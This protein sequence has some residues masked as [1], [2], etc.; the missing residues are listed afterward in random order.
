MPERTTVAVIGAGAVGSY[1]GA[2]LA[3]AG[4]EVRFLF[5]R[6]Y[7]S[8]STKGLTVT[9]PDGDFR[10]A[11][12]IIAKDSGELGAADWVICALKATSIHSAKKLVQP[13]IGPDTR[14]LVLMNGLGLED[15]FA[16][17]FGPQRIFGGLAFTCINRGEPGHIH[18]LAYGTVTI[19]HFRDDTEELEK[20]MD[21]WRGSKVQVVS[22]PSLLRARWE[23][24]CWNITFSGLC[25]A[26]GGITTD[27]IIADPGLHQAA[28]GLMAEVI[29]AGNA[30]LAHH[31]QKD[32]IDMPGMI[33][34]M[35]QKTSTMG[36]YKPS[37]MIDFVEGRSM[38]IESIFGKPLRRAQLLDVPVPRLS[39]LTSILRSLNR[40]KIT[41]S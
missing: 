28:L 27:R 4:R 2:R 35:F 6:D 9:S 41:I 37:T 32:R 29:A 30:D 13:C 17:W 31:R 12:P 36:A 7:R 26:A 21:L 14:I 1:Y 24:L 39:L 11:H 16:E 22:A 8:V 25:V 10:L 18:H 40:D 34:S 23:K 15:I 38:E 3:E 20:A 19:G 33:E 5:R